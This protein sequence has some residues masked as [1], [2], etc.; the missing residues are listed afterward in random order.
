MTRKQLRTRK[1]IPRTNIPY[2]LNN[3]ND[4]DVIPDVS[5]LRFICDSS[6]MRLAKHL[7]LL[8]LDC[9]FEKDANS[10]YLMYLARKENRIILTKNRT[11]V[12]LIVN[13]KEQYEQRSMNRGKENRYDDDDQDPEK[14]L[15]IEQWIKQKQELK[16]KEQEQQQQQ[17]E[18]LLDDSEEDDEGEEEFYE[19]LYYFITASK[20][21][22]QIDEVVNVFQISCDLN[23]VFTVCIKCNA[24]VI[25]IMNKE[26]IRDK[27]FPSVYKN[28]DHFFQCSNCESVYWGTRLRDNACKFAMDHSFKVQHDE[29]VDSIVN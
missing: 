3:D 19:Q 10:Y 5:S 17:Q 12:Q 1:A 6:L 27:V 16:E 22:P 11:M 28:F 21:I 18:L 29:D 20:P 7:R 4:D 25:E 24:P 8:G 14:Q 26:L 15:L 9:A 13:R 2:L 23:K